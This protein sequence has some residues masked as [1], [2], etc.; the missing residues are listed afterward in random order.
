MNVLT[1][2]A[3][4]ISALHIIRHYV[5]NTENGT[6]PNEDMWRVAEGNLRLW[7]GYD[8]STMW[9][10]LG[11]SIL[12]GAENEFAINLQGMGD[13][14]GGYHG[15]E[16]V[17]EEGDYTKFVV[18]GEAYTYD[19][20]VEMGG[21]IECK[22]F[23][24]EQVSTLYASA[25]YDSSHPKIGKHYKKTVFDHGFKTTNYVVFD[26]SALETDT[27]KLL[28]AYSGLLCIHKDVADTIVSDIGKEYETTHPSTTAVLA[29][30]INKYSRRVAMRNGKL[31]CQIDSHVLKSSINGVTDDN[32]NN[33]E[34]YDRVNDAKYYAQLPV[35]QVDVTSGDYIAT[36]C[37]VQ[38]Y[39]NN[40]E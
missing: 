21:P 11:K 29:S 14:T 26:F 3:D 4:Q 37:E 30:N 39:Y 35:Y 13:H 40:M 36:E 20:L 18:D 15:N 38:F 5:N 9:P 1:K 24:Y 22:S 12:V 25:Q 8:A 31:S 34:I 2:V 32:I 33:I 17:A 28:N 23:Y 27:I 10:Q 6:N 16:K 7:N 19:E